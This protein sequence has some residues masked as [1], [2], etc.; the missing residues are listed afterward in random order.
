MDRFSGLISSAARDGQM[1]ICQKKLEAV[2]R[3]ANW[4]AAERNRID[5]KT[6]DSLRA[7]VDAAEALWAASQADEQ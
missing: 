5:G 1:Q 7:E 3:N 6:F 4:Y 2:G